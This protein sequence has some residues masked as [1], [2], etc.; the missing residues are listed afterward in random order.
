MPYWAVISS[1]APQPLN[2]ILDILIVHSDRGD[3]DKLSH[4]PRQLMRS[5][6]PA[7][8]SGSSLVLFLQE[9]QSR[10]LRVRNARCFWFISSLPRD[11]GEDRRHRKARLQW[12][13]SWWVFLWVCD[14]IVARYKQRGKGW[15]EINCMGLWVWLSG[16]L[17]IILLFEGF[18]MLCIVFL[19]F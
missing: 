1:P 6:P 11:S 12:H 7:P 2:I 14:G 15:T 9:P 10:Q 19:M 3:R 17:I 18:D 4:F 16:Q 13:W 5:I 8:L